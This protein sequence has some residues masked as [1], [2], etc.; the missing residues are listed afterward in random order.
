MH[1]VLYAADLNK[2]GLDMTSKKTRTEVYK[3][4]FCTEESD[5]ASDMDVGSV[6]L[7]ESHDW[8]VCEIWDGNYYS[9]F[10][11]IMYNMHV[12]L[13]LGKKKLLRY[14]ESNNKF[15]VQNDDDD[16]KG[17]LKN[18]IINFCLLNFIIICFLQDHLRLHI[19]QTQ[20][21]LRLT[22]VELF[23]CIVLRRSTT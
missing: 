6:F 15:F 5:D 23:L 13:L 9:F 12:Y 11:C 18:C 17:I 22:G 14:D 10:S 1:V 7:P 19:S 2:Q 4:M 16:D 20:A 21:W 3:D 8:Q